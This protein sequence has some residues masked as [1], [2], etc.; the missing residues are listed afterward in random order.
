MSAAAARNRRAQ[1]LTLPDA[2][3]AEHAGWPY[4]TVI[5]A[6]GYAHMTQ[7]ENFD[8]LHGTFRWYMSWGYSELTS[9]ADEGIIWI[10]GWHERESSE[11]EALLAA[12]KLA[13][14][15]A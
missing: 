10:R 6:S 11:V 5:S 8:A 7:A 14:S 9:V 1:Q 4:I 13:R 3:Y 15:A 12:F 2:L